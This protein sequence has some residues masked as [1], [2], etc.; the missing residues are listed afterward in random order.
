MGQSL[1]LLSQSQ[2]HF[3]KLKVEK[4]A[5]ILYVF[6]STKKYTL[7]FICYNC[8]LKMCILT[9]FNGNVQNNCNITKYHQLFK[10]WHQ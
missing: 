10:N 3:C 2:K 8:M 1:Y 9:F 4:K 5:Y 7:K 6:V